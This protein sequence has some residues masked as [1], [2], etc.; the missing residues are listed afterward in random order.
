MSKKLAKKEYTPLM[1]Y[2][3]SHRLIKVIA[4]FEDMDMAE[5]VDW[6]ATRAYDALVLSKRTNTKDHEK[7]DEKKQAN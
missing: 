5:W 2:K 6:I 1:V 3:E 7:K 4:S